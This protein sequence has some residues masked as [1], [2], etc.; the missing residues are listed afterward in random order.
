[1]DFFVVDLEV[2]ATDEELGA[3]L[4]VAIDVTENVLEA[5]GDD[6]GTVRGAK[7]S[8][9]LAAA[10]LAIGKDGTVIALDDGFYEGEG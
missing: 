4:G 3:N 6:T 2:G 9:G 10:G 1:M 8:V 7:H 5:T